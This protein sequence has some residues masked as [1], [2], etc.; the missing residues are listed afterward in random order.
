M[1]QWL[2]VCLEMQGTLV[3]SLVWEDPTLHLKP[4][5]RNQGSHKKPEYHREEQPD[6]CN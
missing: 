2:R 1:V 5:L 4:G 6:G 3:P